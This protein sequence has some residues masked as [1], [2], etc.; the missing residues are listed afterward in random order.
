MI[1]TFLFGVSYGFTLFGLDFTIRFL[2]E[3]FNAAFATLL[4]FYVRLGIIVVLLTELEKLTSF[5]LLGGELT[6]D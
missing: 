3:T 4:G 2:F 6:I 5:E 1:K